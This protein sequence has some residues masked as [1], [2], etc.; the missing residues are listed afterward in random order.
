MAK[1][2]PWNRFVQKVYKENPGKTFGECLKIASTL[3]KQGKMNTTMNTTMNKGKM[4]TNMN[5]NM[6]KGK[7]A[8][9][10][11]SKTKKGKKH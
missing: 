11:K 10:K 8:K 5:T 4:N 9:T 3:K 2:T 1:L 6:N 7:N